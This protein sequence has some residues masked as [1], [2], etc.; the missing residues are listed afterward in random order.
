MVGGS[1]D[2]WPDPGRL[3][4]PAA[5]LGK[6]VREQIRRGG[7]EPPLW[8]WQCVRPPSG[9]VAGQEDGQV[10][11]V[12]PQVTCKT[13]RPGERYWKRG[14]R[15]GGGAREH[16]GHADAGAP[17][18]GAPSVVSRKPWRT[19]HPGLPVDQGDPLCRVTGKSH[20][21]RTEN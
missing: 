13:T 17:G 12:S 20:E 9:G 19:S 3:E 18:R 5:K 16:L 15:P 4:L 8:P 11:D 14:G 21:L 2:F 10:R 7:S 6:V 1:Q